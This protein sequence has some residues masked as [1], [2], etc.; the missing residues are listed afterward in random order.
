MAT[1][2]KGT[3]AS[4]QDNFIGPNVVTGVTTSD[5]GTNRAYN[6]G[7]ISVSWTNPTTGNTPTGYKIYDGATLKA[8]ITHPTNSATVGGY[9]TG[10][11]VTLSVAAYDSY[12]EAAKVNGTA[13]TVT[14]VPATPSAPSASSPTP[15]AAVNTAGSTTDSVSWSAPAN[16]GKAITQYTWT[17]SDGKSGTTSS[18]SVTVNQEGGTAQTYQV[19]AENAN[20]VGA[21]SA[22]SASVTTFSF[23]PFSFAPFG[24][25]GF[26]PFG[27]F[28]FTPFGAFG[29]TPF[30]FS[31]GSGCIEENTLI[32]TTSGLKAAKDVQVGDTVLAVDLVEI[33]T[34]GPEG[35][36][37]YTNFNSEALTS[38]GLIEV[39][40]VSIIP[41][42]KYSNLSFNGESTKKYSSTQPFFVKRGS[43]Y[44]V[45][46]S[47]EIEEGDSLIKVNEDGSLSEVF[48]ESIEYQM[49]ECA[50]YQFNCEPQDWFIA[51]DYLVHNK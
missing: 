37:D 45:I 20:G 22:S 28:G 46:P 32:R 48:I 34:A 10:A 4:A 1:V 43:F 26:T 18:T 6:D 5:V 11:S 47:S 31:P 7:A 17:S 42:T 39:N 12:G 21:Y 2:R 41:S 44:Q 24:A 38:N 30:G 50:V 33:P 23:T 9:A 19:R 25:F 13:V 8:T 27:A 16:G 35:D 40:V 49:T 51:G 3:K 15:S 36:F 14:T 29:F